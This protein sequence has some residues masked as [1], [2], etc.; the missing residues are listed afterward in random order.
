MLRREGTYRVFEVVV[1]REGD[2]VADV[3][4]ETTSS[5]GLGIFLWHCGCGWWGGFRY[6]VMESISLLSISRIK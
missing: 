4:A 5:D 2:L 6:A 1:R 3:L